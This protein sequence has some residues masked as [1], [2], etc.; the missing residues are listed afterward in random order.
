MKRIAARPA[1]LGLVFTAAL[2]AG[3]GPAAAEMI[4]LAADDRKAIEKYLGP[5]VI[6]DAVEGNP[7]ADAAQFFAFEDGAWTFRFTNGDNKGET[8]EQSFK[9]L[10]RDKDG[11]TG[12][13]SNGP[14]LAYFLRRGPEGDISIASEQDTDQGV[15][16]RFSPPEPFYVGKLHPG[17]SKK[18]KIDVK[19]YDL[20]SPDEV[21]H[22]GS[23]DLTLSYLGAYHVTVPA[24]TYE[25]ALL[26]WAYDG[27]VG[28]A[29]IKDT[30]YRFLVEGVGVVA[31]VEKK[32][33]SAMLIYHD[34]SKY[35]KVLVGGN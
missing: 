35:G 24:G 33:I 12:R 19:V 15:I 29:S 7:I 11:T 30:Q 1:V 2:L 13:Y 25:A 14:N 16:S 6:G 26:K 8:Q 5:D 22:K 20:S 32:N 21:S 18:T 31:V 17:D 34:N 23:L 9:K 10:K 4:E 28:P 27:K 3:P